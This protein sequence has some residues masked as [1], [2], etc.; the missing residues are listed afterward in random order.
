MTWLARR[1]RSERMRI[2]RRAKSGLEMSIWSKSF[3]FSTSSFVGSTATAVADRGLRSMRAISPKRS[4]VWSVVRVFAAEGPVALRISTRPWVITYISAPSSPS[5]KIT[6]SAPKSFR[7]RSKVPLSI[8]ISPH[9][10]G[11]PV[12]RR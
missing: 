11:P 4:P 9:P 8:F 6:A 10:P 3:S 12:P 7:C 2:I 1:M 5:W